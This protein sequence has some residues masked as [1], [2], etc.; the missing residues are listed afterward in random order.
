MSQ[1]PHFIFD[2]FRS[3]ARLQFSQAFMAIMAVAPKREIKKTTACSLC[4]APRP[5][6]GVVCGGLVVGTV[7]GERLIA[8]RGE[9][10]R[11]PIRQAHGQHA[12]SWRAE[13]NFH[14]G[15]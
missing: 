13:C 3:L 12:R 4:C 11:A 9:H 2:Y 6:R 14:K 7:N 10:P 1:K 5:C 8:P 15:L